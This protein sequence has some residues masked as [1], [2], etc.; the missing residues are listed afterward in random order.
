MAEVGNV[1]HKIILIMVLG[2]LLR[3]IVPMCYLGM[4]L[5]L[6]LEGGHR[7]VLNWAYI[8]LF[9]GFGVVLYMLLNEPGYGWMPMWVTHEMWLVLGLLVLLLLGAVLFLA[10]IELQEL[11]PPQA[12]LHRRYH[13]VQDWLR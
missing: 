6:G 9:G 10:A 13:M 1:S 8:L 3:Q 5:Y 7:S 11:D 12:W 4:A 2:D